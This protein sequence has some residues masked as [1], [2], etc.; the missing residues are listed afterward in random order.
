MLSVITHG[1]QLDEVTVSVIAAPVV[2][3]YEPD[4]VRTL[5]GLHDSHI[6]VDSGSVARIYNSAS[7]QPA[8]QPK[9]RDDKKYITQKRI[10][11]NSF[12]NEYSWP[13]T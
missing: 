5:S 9:N 8:A 3:S 6:H 13:S 7:Q 1:T 10:K 4:F 12:G 2:N 11:G